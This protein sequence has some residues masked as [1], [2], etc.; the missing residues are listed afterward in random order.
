MVRNIITEG[1]EQARDNARD[2]L[3]DVRQAMGLS[4]L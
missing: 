1:C 3:N 4:Y 2:T